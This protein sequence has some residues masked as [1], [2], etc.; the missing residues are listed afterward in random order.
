MPSLA[1]IST[2]SRSSI[3]APA[4]SPACRTSASDHQAAASS[5]H[6]GMSMGMDMDMEALRALHVSAA[7]NGRVRALR[8]EAQRRRSRRQAAACPSVES[9]AAHSR[10]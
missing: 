6:M 4:A 9:T 7:R 10:A 1:A 5:V 8:M 2:F 3:K